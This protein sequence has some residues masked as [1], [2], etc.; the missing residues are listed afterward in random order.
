MTAPPAAPRR[1]ISLHRLEAFSDAAFGFAITL[2]VVSL[3]VPRS[4]QALF[5]MMRGFLAF[6]IT[7]AFLCLVWYDHARFFRRHPLTDNITVALNM[8]LLFVVLLYVYP[9]KFL[10]SLLVDAAVFRLPQTAVQSAPEWKMLMQVYGLGFAALHAIFLGMHL[11]AR[12]MLTYDE[13]AAI[14]LAGSVRR[15]LANMLVGLL[16]V[17][18]ARYTSDRGAVAGFA[19][20]LIVPLLT[21]NGWMTGRAKRAVWARAAPVQ[22]EEAAAPPAESAESATTAGPAATEDGAHAA[23]TAMAP[24]TSGA[25]GDGRTGK[26]QANTSMRPPPDPPIAS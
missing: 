20:F 6:G 19:Y 21:L 4:A 23:P 7:L 17:A 11:H 9:M 5:D 24:A 14:E 10:F 8:L 25:D 3:E 18:I 16:S 15:H 1:H 2:L 22:T 12:R 26:A 13:I